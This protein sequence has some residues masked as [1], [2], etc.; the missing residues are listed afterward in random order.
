MI[1]QIKEVCGRVLY[2]L[3]IVDRYFV[4]YELCNPTRR[5]YDFVYIV[6]ARN[7][8]H[9]INIVRRKHGDSIR[10]VSSHRNGSNIIWRHD[11]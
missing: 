3:G 11:G 7:H 6:Y 9:A 1:E 4:A 2:A 8:Y 5:D 10:V